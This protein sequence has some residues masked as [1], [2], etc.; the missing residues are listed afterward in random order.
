MTNVFV[1]NRQQLENN[2]NTPEETAS[3][4]QETDSANEY[5]NIISDG[6]PISAHT[7]GIVSYE[8]HYM[9]TNLSWYDKLRTISPLAID[10][11]RNMWG[12]VD[13]FGRHVYDAMKRIPHVYVPYDKMRNVARGD[14]NE[15]GTTTG[16]NAYDTMERHPEVTLPSRSQIV[17]LSTA[18]NI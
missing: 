14:L 2:D 6:T 5:E 18:E 8:R 10:W 13:E 15:N 12:N 1:G 7:R 4:S 11:L 16:S 9:N 17:V 3:S